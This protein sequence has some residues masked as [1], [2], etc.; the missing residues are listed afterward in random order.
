MSLGAFAT[1]LASIVALLQVW[2]L[3]NQ[4]R[5]IEQQDQFI[6]LQS[7]TGKLQTVHTILRGVQDASDRYL[8][9][10]QLSTLGSEGFRLLSDIALQDSRYQ[11]IPLDILISPFFEKTAEQ[12]I[13][14]FNV[15]SELLS[16]ETGFQVNKN[17]DRAY[18][19]LDR[20]N[21]Y[22]D[23]NSIS[24]SDLEGV[25]K[26]DRSKSKKIMFEL[27]KDLIYFEFLSDEDK[28]K[29]YEVLSKSPMYVAKY[30]GDNDGF[31]LFE[32]PSDEAGYL[33]SVGLNGLVYSFASWCGLK[34]RN[35]MTDRL[36]ENFRNTHNE[37]LKK[38]DESDGSTIYSH[39]DPWKWNKLC[40]KPFI[41]KEVEEEPYLPRE[42]IIYLDENKRSGDQGRRR[43]PNK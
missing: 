29:M 26:A 16:S 11:F 3:F 5:L 38:S 43:S 30:G 42:N 27:S 17:I 32:T 25:S 37:R 21:D 2:L 18:A 6:E 20:L 23:N 40:E 35:K 28:D 39:K 41:L 22:I 14:V 8:A 31:S 7:Q 4:N 34:E 1:I 12:K 15:L 33:F 10:T 13:K 36:I 24:F 19:F 9:I